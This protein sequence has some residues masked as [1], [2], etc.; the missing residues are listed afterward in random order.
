M[1]QDK[2]RILV[3]DD[4]PD[5]RRVTTMMLRQGGYLYTEASSGPE[6]LQLLRQ[7]PETFP[8]LISDLKMPEMDGEAL[9]REA[10]AC[11]PEL[12]V[13]F[14]TG[15]SGDALA[16]MRLKPEQTS[17]LEKPFTIEELLSQVRSIL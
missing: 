10:F 14:V 16:A 5:V 7:A 15:F 9:A 12:K 11:C 6:A 13:L 8:L 17:I 2:T 1:L 3:V 4:D